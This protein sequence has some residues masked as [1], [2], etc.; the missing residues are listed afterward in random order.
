MAKLHSDLSHIAATA[1]QF[2]KEA[3]LLTAADIVAVAKQLA[4]VDTG[5][6]QQSL[7]AKP[8]SSTKVMVGSDV[9]HAPFV[10]Y[11]T[12]V[13]AAQP[14]LTPAFAQAEATFRKRLQQAI[15]QGVKK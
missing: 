14:Y 12:S 7:G 2:A 8:V 13:S 3:L 9:E 4:P 1:P 11:G 10:E 15:D 6:L 5:A